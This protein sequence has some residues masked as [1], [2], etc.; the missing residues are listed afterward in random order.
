MK[1]RRPAESARTGAAT[2]AH[3]TVWEVLR[4]ALPV[5]LA[6]LATARPEAA[7]VA[8]R[9]LGDLP[10]VAAECGERCGARG[11]VPHLPETADRAGSSRLV[12][13]ARRL[14]DALGGGGGRLI[15]TATP[16]TA[17]VPAPLNS[18]KCNKEDGSMLYPSVTISS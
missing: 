15:R 8:A 5:P 16:A 11:D 4:H 14:R 3:A 9:G 12:A 10:A 13:Q 7:A 6:G 17:P 1:A 18:R 2:G